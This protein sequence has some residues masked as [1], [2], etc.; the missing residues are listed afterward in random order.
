MADFISGAGN[1]QDEHRTSCHT[2]WQENDWD[3]F[4]KAQELLLSKEEQI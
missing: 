1:V 2:K 4:F 3:F